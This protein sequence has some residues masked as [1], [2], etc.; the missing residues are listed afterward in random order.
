MAID[1]FKN[2]KNY[3]DSFGAEVVKNAKDNLKKAKKQV[4][5]L[6]TSLRLH[7]AKL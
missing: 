6:K 2:L 1:D 4:V 7:S 3:L 5:P